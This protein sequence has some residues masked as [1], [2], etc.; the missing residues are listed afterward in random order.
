[1]EIRK[2]YDVYELLDL[3]EHVHEGI[4]SAV[5]STQFLDVFHIGFLKKCFVPLQQ[6]FQNVRLLVVDSIT[7]II[8]PLMGGDKDFTGQGMMGIVARTLNYLA[9]RCNIAVLVSKHLVMHAIIDY[10]RNTR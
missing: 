5:S 6:K 7:A 9:L 4:V 2:V 3:L 8:S 1:M 10:L